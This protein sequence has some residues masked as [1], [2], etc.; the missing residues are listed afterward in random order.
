VVILN[1]VLIAVN[2]RALRPDAVFQWVQTHS[3]EIIFYMALRTGVIA[4]ALMPVL[5]LFATRNNLLLWLTNWSYSTFLL[6][7]RWI[8][9]IFLFQALLHSILFLAL[10]I[11]LDHYKRDL[12]TGFWIW[13][14]VAT[15]AAVAVILTSALIVRRKA[16][17][18]FF[19]SH[20]V[21]SVFVVVGCWYHVVLWNTY[22]FGYETWLYMT[23]A[24]WFFDRLVQFIRICAAGPKR[25]HVSTVSSNVLRVDIPELRWGAVPGQRIHVY[26]P[27]LSWWRAHEC[28]PFSVVPTMLFAK[29]VGSSHNSLSGIDHSKTVVVDNLVEENGSRPPTDEAWS[30]AGVTLFIRE[31]RGFTSLITDCNQLLT[32]VDGPYPGAATRSVLNCDRVLLIGGGIGI[33]GL[34]AW[35]QHHRNTKLFYSAKD[36]DQNFVDSL[37]PALEFAQEKEIV[38]GRRLVIP[39]LLQEEAGIGW[40]KIGVVVCGPADMCDEVRAAVAKIAKV[41]AGVCSFELEVASFSW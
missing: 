18:L 38:V 36:S 19:A 34:L 12:T 23:I 4:F 37:S 40:Q 9:R 25:A 5:F 24:V 35:L 15:V 41:K 1:A 29:P 28:H 32:L 26:F 14:C 22:T 39:D 7:H 20:V 3:Q 21:L 33:T 30:G 27:T 10:W 17:N 8:G 2:Y 6:L 13:G 31:S 11:D 16:Y